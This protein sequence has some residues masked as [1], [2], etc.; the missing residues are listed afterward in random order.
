MADSLLYAGRLFRSAFLLFGSADI[1]GSTVFQNTAMHNA[2]SA[3]NT[4]DLNT[5][6]ICCIHLYIST[7]AHV[8]FIHTYIGINIKG[9]CVSVLVHTQKTVCISIIG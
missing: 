9:Q 5:S 3:R 6:E 4:E 7:H 8:H 1:V 2:R